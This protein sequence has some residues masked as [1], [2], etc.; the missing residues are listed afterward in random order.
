[1]LNHIVL[2]PQ[3]GRSYSLSIKEFNEDTAQIVVYRE[4]VALAYLEADRIG[5]QAAARPRPQRF[6]REAYLARK[7]DKRCRSNYSA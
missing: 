5:C 3:L 2:I 1:M 6:T 4:Q 7:G